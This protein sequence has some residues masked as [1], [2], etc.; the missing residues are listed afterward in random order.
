MISLSDD[1]DCIGGEGWYNVSWTRVF[2]IFSY[3]A[4]RIF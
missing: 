2:T 1:F 3:V 4:Q